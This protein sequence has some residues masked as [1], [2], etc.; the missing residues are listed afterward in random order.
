MALLCFLGSLALGHYGLA[1][2]AD[3]S[4]DHMFGAVDGDSVGAIGDV[5][6][7]GDLFKVFKVVDKLA[8]GSEECGLRALAVDGLG[9]DARIASNTGALNT[10]RSRAVCMATEDNC[11]DPNSEWLAYLPE[12]L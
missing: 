10:G 6:G 8:H 5:N 3:A 2:G 11:N 1:V 4:L 12:Q 7:P 9:G